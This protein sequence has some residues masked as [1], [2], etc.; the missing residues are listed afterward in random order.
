MNKKILES[1]YQ[2]C[3][4]LTRKHYENFPVASLLIPKS[5]RKY[6]AAIYTFARI[7]DDIADEN[8]L[9]QTKKTSLLIEYKDYFNSFLVTEKYPH[10]TAVYDTIEKNNLTNKYFNDLIQAFIQDTQISSYKTFGEVLN[11]CTLSAN[12]VG[13]ILLELF[14]IRSEEANLLSDKICTAL[15]LTNFYQD[16]SIDIPRERFY[17]PEEYLQKF[18]LIF[19]DL[20]KFAEM[21]QVNS[22]FTELMKFLIDQTDQM[23]DEGTKLLTYLNGLFRKEIQLTIEGGRGI[24][25]KIVKVNYNT[26]QIRPTLDKFDWIKILLRVIL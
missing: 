12:P 14:D 20:K 22:N 17:I 16:L 24:L 11:Y 1:S 23:F 13:R 26:F 4:E 5:K 18:N 25:R 19:D 8:N 9:P 2:Y 21:K 3:F 6:I 7:A 10:F 15:Q